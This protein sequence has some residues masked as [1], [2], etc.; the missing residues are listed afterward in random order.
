[1]SS[2]PKRMKLIIREVDERRGE[3][4]LEL[5]S[6]SVTRGVVPRSYLT[7]NVPRADDLSNYKVCRTGDIVVNRMS[8]YQGALGLADQDGIVSPDYIVFRPGS[9]VAPR[10]VH[11][12]MRSDFFVSEMAARIRGIGSIGTSNV[13]TPRVSSEEI[14]EI[15]VV[16]PDRVSQQRIADYLDA[17]T[18][19][20]D[21]L[22]TKKQRMIELFE[23]RRVSTQWK[24]LVEACPHSVRLK[25]L[26]TK[27][28]SGSTPRGGA[29]VYVDE[30]VAFLRSQNIRD[31]RVNHDDV[32]YISEKENLDM[33]PTQVQEGD[34]LLNITGGSI[35]R[36]A[37]VSAKDLPANV[38]QHVCIIRPRV[39]VSPIILQ[40]A[41][42]TS[43]VREQ[44][45]LV[46]VGG[47][48]EGL[49]FEQIRRLEVHVPSSSCD[50][51]AAAIRTTNE[52]HRQAGLKLS[53]QV[54]LLREHKQALITA[55]VTG[56]LEI[57]EVA[58]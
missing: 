2:V 55:A 40:A 9:E 35:G 4:E 14:G 43:A 18:A 15:R 33:S 28:G 29:E 42:D 54:E 25:T 8:A 48:R 32:V 44:I 41:L 45:A 20:I 17:E 19:R 36:T 52:T 10:W 57:L 30:G 12:L 38:S 58:A 27:I 49:N 37:V 1:V 3:Q 13:R 50:D 22:I 7:D 24:L 26:V 56:E 5:L 53:R 16:L 11:H 51:L 39:G 23:T 47:N 46:Q 31:G 6:V 34:V 21:A